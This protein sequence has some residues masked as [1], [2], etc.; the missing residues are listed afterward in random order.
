MTQAEAAAAGLELTTSEAFSIEYNGTYADM[1]AYESGTATVGKL[2]VVGGEVNQTVY[3]GHEIS[4][5]T[6]KWG[7]D[8]TSVARKIAL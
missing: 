5:V 3:I 6:I 1:G 2:Y 4:P 7:A 8:G